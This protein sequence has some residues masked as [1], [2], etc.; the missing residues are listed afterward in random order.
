MSSSYRLLRVAVQL[1]LSVSIVAFFPWLALLVLGVPSRFADGRSGDALFVIGTL[2]A[3][4]SLGISIVMPIHRRRLI[5]LRIV[6]SAGLLMALWI[7]YSI[8]ANTPGEISFEESYVIVLCSI[9]GPAVVAVWNIVRMTRL[10]RATDRNETE[11]N[12]ALQ[13]TPVTRSE[14]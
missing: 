9:L 1:A 14:I 12:Q 10:P 7:V 5:G 11:P 4:M 13:T 6:V 3:L 8:S 2:F